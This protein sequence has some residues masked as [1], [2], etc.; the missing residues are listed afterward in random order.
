MDS[1]TRSELTA[2]GHCPPFLPVPWEETVSRPNK[3][4]VDEAARDIPVVLNDFVGFSRRYVGP[5]RYIPIGNPDSAVPNVATRDLIEMLEGRGH[6]SFIARRAIFRLIE[7]GFLRAEIAKIY[8]VVPPSRTESEPAC[9]AE[10]DVNQA[11]AA[12]LQDVGVGGLIEALAR[13][14]GPD[15]SLAQVIRDPAKDTAA[16]K[17][18]EKIR[19]CLSVAEALSKQPG[20]V[21]L[22]EFCLPTTPRD[23]KQCHLFSYLVVWPTEALWEWWKHNPS[24]T[25]AVPEAEPAKAG[26]VEIPDE[27]AYVLASTLWK[28]RF[29]SYKQFESFLKRTPEIRRRKP[30]WNRLQIHSGDWVR[31]WAKHDSGQFE[32]LDDEPSCAR[33]EEYAARE[34][35]IRNKKRGK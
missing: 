26:R 11:S 18:V 20:P 2:F 28:D 22:L 10:S 23:V 21:F 29:H 17:I 3:E 8:F 34:V 19:E 27:S 9:A 33:L 25:P 15:V 31:Y 16:T 24:A 1:Y 5:L 13:V 7:C 6:D 35:E 12:N 32:S 4:L 30:V 14:S